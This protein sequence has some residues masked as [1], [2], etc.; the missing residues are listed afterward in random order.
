MKVLLILLLSSLSFAD[1]K[2]I[3][4]EGDL[5]QYI[6]MYRYT[7]GGITKIQLEGELIGDWIKNAIAKVSYADYNVKNVVEVGRSA[8]FESD[9]KYKPRKYFDYIR[10]DLSNLV[11]VK[12]YGRFAPGDQCQIQV[13]I[14]KNAMT[15]SNFSAPT[16]VHCDQSG[17][18]TTLTCK[19]K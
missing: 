13:M 19:T 7:P 4:C 15:R 6:K 5:N 14:P 9:E 1:V 12:N 16:Q 8:Q 10:F 17:G 2:T 3:K 11:E 18:V